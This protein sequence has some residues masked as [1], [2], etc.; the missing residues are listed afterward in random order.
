MCA[1]SDY[2]RCFARGGT[3]VKR[4]R[5]SLAVGVTLAVGAM[6]AVGAMTATAG[7]APTPPASPDAART[8]AAHNAAE[9]VATR[10]AY[11]MASAN[12]QFVQGSVESS[13][14]IQYVPYRRTYGGLPVVGGDFVLVMNKAGQVVYNSTALQHP[15]GTVSTTPALTQGAAE[16]IAGQQ[17]R[18]VSK[19]EGSRLVV[20]A[21]GA[22]SRLA[23][24]STVDGVGADGVSRLSVDVDALTG[25]VLGTQEHVMHGSGSSAWN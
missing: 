14:A 5:R 4:P 10:P 8:L 24:E 9:F 1:P 18:S 17:L 3:S 22:T 23:W 20:H 19:V 16:S 2:R 13:G 7:A 21:L 25:Q 6:A 12:E 11:L 15:I